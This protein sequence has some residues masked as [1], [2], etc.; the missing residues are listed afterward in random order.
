[1]IPKY[2]IHKIQLAI[3]GDASWHPSVHITEEQIVLG[4]LKMVYLF[5]HLFGNLITNLEFSAVHYSESD[6][7]TI[8]QYIAT[9][10]TKSLLHLKITESRKFLFTSQQIH[11]EKLQSFALNDF[12]C[13]FDS[14]FGITFD[15]LHSIELNGRSYDKWPIYFIEENA[16]LK[17]ISFLTLTVQH[18]PNFLK[19]LKQPNKLQAIRFD[20][21]HR[22]L[23]WERDLTQFLDQYSQLHS[24]SVTIFD[25]PGDNSVNRNAFTRIVQ[26][27][28]GNCDI[29]VQPTMSTGVSLVSYTRKMNK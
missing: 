1:M 4:E 22:A 6:T 26:N 17:S 15:N 19:H 11:F 2:R 8:G 3:H 10:C 5:L 7:L 9:Y 21:D 13:K 14:K 27:I 25:W 24:I 28:W 23:N 29:H 20:F 16:E 18:V 12:F